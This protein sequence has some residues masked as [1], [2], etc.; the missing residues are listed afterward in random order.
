MRFTVRDSPDYYNLKVSVF[1]D[2]KKTDIIG[3]TLVNLEDVV[4]P[5]GG[6]SDLWHPLKCKGKY[7]G[8]I[9]FE[10]TYYDNRP[11]IE[12]P[13][14]VGGM[15]QSIAE[16]KRTSLAGPRHETPVKRRPLPADPT[17]HS[18]SPHVGPDSAPRA[19]PSHHD[20]ASYHTPP[21]LRTHRAPDDHNAN[22]SHDYGVDFGAS[23]RPDLNIGPTYSRTPPNQAF[24]RDSSQAHHQMDQFQQLHY[25]QA[26]DFG[27]YHS[28]SNGSR[29][30]VGPDGHLAQENRGPRFDDAPSK[31]HSYAATSFY[32]R[33]QVSA[34]RPEHDVHFLP[35][36]QISPSRPQ[37]S[38]AA[39]HP[40]SAPGIPQYE[41]S[42][43]E[44]SQN[45]FPHDRFHSESHM[46]SQNSPHHDEYRD[47]HDDGSF[48]RENSQQR[49]SGHQMDAQSNHSPHCSYDLPGYCDQ[50]NQRTSY[51]GQPGV[52]ANYM[53]PTVED[54]DD[55][56]PPPPIHRNSPSTAV[57]SSPSWRHTYRDEMQPSPFEPLRKRK[58]TLIHQPQQ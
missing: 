49:L 57:H 37:G 20:V 14:D 7:A 5:G 21:P 11:K 22:H 55:V 26:N 2:D 17:G 51:G 24:N 53:Q 3:E 6:Q 36:H 40:P 25:G 30:F 8:E 47:Q 54:D 50:T 39:S 35:P 52:P 19:L 32:E 34:A 15:P 28:Q 33:S 42:P 27:S 41:H 56:P 23:D 13:A 43:T 12:K 4:V 48:R 29:E 10:M 1:N 38:I 45:G 58:C 9:R 44:I 46:L 16:S 31:R 18:P